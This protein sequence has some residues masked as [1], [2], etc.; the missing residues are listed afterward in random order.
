MERDGERPSVGRARKRQ[1]T[2]RERRGETK[3]VETRSLA[4]SRVSSGKYEAHR[5]T[6]RCVAEL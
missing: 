4:S 3:R 6:G 5:R 2:E 1:R